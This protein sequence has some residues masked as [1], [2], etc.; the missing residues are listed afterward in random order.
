M[1]RCVAEVYIFAPLGSEQSF[2]VAC[3]CQQNPWTDYFASMERFDQIQLDI[4]RSHDGN[5]D[6]R[7]SSSLARLLFVWSQAHPDVQYRQGMHDIAS[8]IWSV[9]HSESNQSGLS[10]LL[11]GASCEHD[12]YTVFCALME[13][14]GSLYLAEPLSRH[15]L[16]IRQGI[17]QVDPAL[18]AHLADLGIE[19]Q[20]FALRWLR[21]LFSRELPYGPLLEL[22][23]RI[24]ARV[25]QV[26]LLDW[27]CVAAMLR[28]RN[29]L[30]S[31]DQGHVWTLLMQPWKPVKHV[32]GDEPSGETDTYGISLLVGQANKLM[33]KPDPSTGVECAVQNQELLG[34]PLRSPAS[35]SEKT[36]EDILLSSSLDRRMAWGTLDSVSKSTLT[37][38]SKLASWA[39]TNASQN[40]SGRTIPPN[41]GRRDGFPE[42]WTVAEAGKHSTDQQK[43]RPQTSLSKS[44]QEKMSILEQAQ[45]REEQRRLNVRRTLEQTVKDLE[46]SQD[47]LEEKY[48]RALEALR[49]AVAAL[50][51]DT[52]ASIESSSRLSGAPSA[53]DHF[54]NQRRNQLA[55]DEPGRKT[56][57][58]TLRPFQRLDDLQ[59]QQQG[60][61]V[62][63]STSSETQGDPLGAV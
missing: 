37:S 10:A 19:T 61:T 11:G 8:V 21:L 56:Q 22:W 16:E 38:A 27:I 23:D 30:L 33:T 49:S 63:A 40:F 59:Q 36:A 45:H 14:W 7:R 2:L 12:T 29:D 57:H 34:I 3:Y 53:S 35:A 18:A 48:E 55:A 50:D 62:A 15:V 4:A 32:P 31:D 47:N 1:R 41:S 39:Y 54:A 44:F 58:G 5:T 20:V 24:I 42:R 9:R 6:H 26:L 25:D 28:M 17:S 13:H 46:K 52:A 43:Q 51:K 60:G